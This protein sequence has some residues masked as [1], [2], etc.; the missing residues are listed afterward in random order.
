MVRPV[1]TIGLDEPEALCPPVF[2]VTVYEVI[3]APPVEV[4][5]VN[6]TDACPLLAVAV[7]IVGAPGITAEIVKDLLTRVAAL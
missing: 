3:D 7:P 1:T 2:D 5:A 6:A 4:G